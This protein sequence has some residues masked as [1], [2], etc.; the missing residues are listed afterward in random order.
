MLQELKMNKKGISEVIGYVLLVVIAIS[1]SL[2]VYAWLKN[3]MPGEIE[4]CSDSASLAIT[5]YSCNEHKIT[6][7]IKNNGLFNL[8]GFIARVREEENGFFYELKNGTNYFKE[9]NGLEPNEEDIRIFSYE[10]HTQII[11]IQIQPFILGKKKEVI[12]CDSAFI[13]QKLENCS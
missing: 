2:L 9:E 3:Y 7:G 12:L 1:L 8:Y 13:S 4:K 5:D 11:E 10:N 6:L